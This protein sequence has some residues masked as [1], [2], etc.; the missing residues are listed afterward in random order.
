[1]VSIHCSAKVR[2]HRFCSRKEPHSFR[3]CH[4][5]FFCTTNKVDMVLPASLEQASNA[6]YATSSGVEG[7]AFAGHQCRVDKYQNGDLFVVR[8]FHSTS[9]SHAGD[10]W[11]QSKVKASK[12]AKEAARNDEFGLD[13]SRYFGTLAP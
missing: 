5:S 10:R 8:G 1:M 3:A 7:E 4:E 2:K 6:K 11:F 12:E 9:L 13:Q